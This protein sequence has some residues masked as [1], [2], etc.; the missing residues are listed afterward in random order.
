MSEVYKRSLAHATEKGKGRGR[1]GQ[2][3]FGQVSAEII[4]VR[5]S[6]QGIAI[7]TALKI[8]SEGQTEVR[9]SPKEIAE[10]V[11]LARSTAIKKLEELERAGFVELIDAGEG[12]KTIWK[13]N[14]HPA[15]VEAA[16]N[17]ASQIIER[18][19]KEWKKRHPKK[20]LVR[21]AD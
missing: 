14:D 9:A 2:K 1:F 8:M 19:R 7:F 13:I 20:N 5:I 17:V 10:A 21:E 11:S 16:R 6:A 3:S 15:H 4:E 12:R 18:R